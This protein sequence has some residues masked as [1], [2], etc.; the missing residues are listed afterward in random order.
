M[1]S[2]AL[3]FNGTLPKIDDL[4]VETMSR[5]LG[6]TLPAR[7]KRDPKQNIALRWSLDRNR[8]LKRGAA[9]GTS[10]HCRPHVTDSMY[11]YVLQCSGIHDAARLAHQHG[12]S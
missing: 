7:F 8:Y 6:P 12:L 3:A 1:R 5:T 2:D 10:F 4:V 9:Y 11:T